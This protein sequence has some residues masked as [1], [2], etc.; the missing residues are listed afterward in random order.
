[1]AKT[2]ECDRCQMFSGHLG[3][4]YLV[5]GIHPSGST[6][7]PCPDFAL[8][9][10]NWVPV[11]A[12]YYGGELVRDWPSYLSSA[13]RLHL[14]ETHPLFTGVC[15]QCRFRYPETPAVHWDCPNC[16]W[17]DDTVV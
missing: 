14:I 9:V 16:G 4:E 12:A 7:T 1:M 2:D 8:V 5:C 17:V 15:P 10:E 6:E 11:G 3:E 13:D